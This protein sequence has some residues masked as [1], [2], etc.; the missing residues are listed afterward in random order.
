M[1]LRN[2]RT[3]PKR[4][5]TDIGL[6]IGRDPRIQPDYEVARLSFQRSQVDLAWSSSI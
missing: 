5:V 3:A 2:L 1:V 4:D 6:Q